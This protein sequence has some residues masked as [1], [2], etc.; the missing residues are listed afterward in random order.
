LTRENGERFEKGESYEALSQTG[1]EKKGRFRY[2]VANPGDYRILLDNRL[3]GRDPARMQ[4]KASLLYHEYDS[5]LPKT[6]SPVRRRSIAA[7]SL[8]GFAVVALVVGRKLLPV[9]RC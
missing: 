4:V 2:L 9:M 5:F 6:L 1:Y 3:E 7:A 8:A